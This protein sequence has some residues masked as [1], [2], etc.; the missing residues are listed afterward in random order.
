MRRPIEISPPAPAP[1]LSTSLFSQPTTAPPPPS[2]F[3]SEPSGPSLFDQFKSGLDIEEAL[4]TDWLNKIG[5]AIL[6]LGIAFF[7]AYQL[8]TLGPLG[9]V[10]VGLATAGVMLGAGIWFERGDRYRILARAGI[11]GGWAL[12]FFT[13]TMRGFT[14]FWLI[15][16][17][18]SWVPFWMLVELAI[19][20]VPA[21]FSRNKS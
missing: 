2:A 20:V 16:S 7:L 12:L 18:G 15:C 9:K 17:N 19:T 11:G 13:T 1:T 10:F 4:G 3:A 6:V 8:K 21:A 5:I 14:V